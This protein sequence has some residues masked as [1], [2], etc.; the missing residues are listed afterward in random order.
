METVTP[1]LIALP[2]LILLERQMRSRMMSP[3]GLTQTETD[4]VTTNPEQ[5]Q[6]L[7]SMMGCHLELLV[8]PSTELA[9]QTAMVMAILTT[10]QDG[11]HIQPVALMHSLLFQR[12][13][14]IRTRTVSAMNRSDSIRIHALQH[15]AIRQATDLVAPIPMEIHS[16]MPTHWATTVQYGQLQTV[17]MFGP[18]SQHN[19]PIRTQ[20][21]TVTIRAEYS[22]TVAQTVQE[23]HPQTDTVAS[24]RMATPTRTQTLGTPLLKVQIH[25][26]AIRCVGPTK[27]GTDLTTKSTTT[28][29]ISGATRRLTEQDAPIQMVT[30]FPTQTQAG[31]LPITALTHSRPT[32]PNPLTLTEMD[33]ATMLQEI[34][35]MTVQMKTETRGRIT[36]LGA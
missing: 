25:I 22:L 13:G 11:S 35:L 30:V 6:M 1:T 19:G 31:H 20:T 10:M 36:S 23:V 8:Q 5:I 29:R 34:S 24:I 16:P 2:W 21:A 28:V 15:M 3:S 14:T 7:V 9:A 4:T 12:S 17:L 27:M 26:P 33:S 18:T 32:P